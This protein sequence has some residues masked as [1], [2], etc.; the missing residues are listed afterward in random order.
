MTDGRGT[1][2]VVLSDRQGF[3]R[4][5]FA[6]NLEAV[7]VPTR[8]EEVAGCVSSAVSRYGR[9]VKITSGRHC[10]EDFVYNDGTRAVIDLSA[11]H[12]VGF[13]P[14][15]GFFVE[16]GCENWTVYRTLLNGYNRTLPAGAATPWAPAGT[17]RVVGTACSP[18]ST[19]SPSTT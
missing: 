7:Y 8:A 9:A 11:L 13:D 14:N 6:P 5:W 2:P 15:H 16:A 17:S 18:A 3:D 1:R 19:A 12:Q 4:R 10:Y